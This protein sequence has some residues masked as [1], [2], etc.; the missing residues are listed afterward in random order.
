MCLK[1]I[2]LLSN[3]SH[4]GLYFSLEKNCLYCNNQS[5]VFLTCGIIVSFDLKSCSPILPISTSSMIIFPIAGSMILNRAKVKDD[6]PAPVRPTIPTCN[7]Q[8]N[9][10]HRCHKSQHSYPGQF[11]T[12]YFWSLLSST[13]STSTQIGV[14]ISVFL[15]WGCSV[16]FL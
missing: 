10:F 6:F 3:V 16:L 7:K 8:Y 4:Y 9:T 1:G 5:Y 11:L 12:A 2:P 13:Q 15:I 14:F